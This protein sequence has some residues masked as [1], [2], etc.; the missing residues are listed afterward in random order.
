MAADVVFLPPRVKRSGF[1]T[2]MPTVVSVVALLTGVK[3]NLIG[4]SV[5]VSLVS[6][7]EPHSPAVEA[8]ASWLFAHLLWRNVYF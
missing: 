5:C 3:C 8:T 6:E 4:V 1:S 2:P 7:V